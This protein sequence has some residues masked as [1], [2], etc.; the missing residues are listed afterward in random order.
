MRYDVARYGLVCDFCGSFK[1][2]HRPEEG[3]VVGEMDFA[4]AIRVADTN[5]GVTRRLVTCKSC[6]AQML[7]DSDQ[8][9]AMCPFC[10]SAIVL[11]AEE[12]N[13]GIAP[14]A[15]IPFSITKEQVIERFYR[16]N[17]FAFWSPEKFRKGKVLGNITPLYIPYWTFDA[18][19]VTTYSG[20]F[21]YTTGSGDS[22]RTAYYLKTGIMEKHIDD[23]CVCGSRKF[24]NDSML[25]KVATFKPKDL[26]AY[27]PEVLSGMPAE[28]Y[29]ISIDEAWVNAKNGGMN[30]KITEAVKAHEMADSCSELRYS[31]EYYNVKYRYV[32][33]PVW[34][35]G[36]K[37]GGRIYNVVASGYNGTGNCNR[38]LSVAKLIA[39]AAV[40]TAC[41]ILG[42]ILNIGPWMIT[43]GVM[44]FFAFVIIYVAMFFVTLSQQRE[45][46]RQRAIPK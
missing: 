16:W 27:S 40:F 22:A 33:V 13:C 2:L 32:L 28:I 20:K 37:Y 25:N 3:A 38:P 19:T 41:V 30:K 10:G 1:P 42:N 6:G 4:S 18:D 23:Y 44:A 21:G 34:L 24:A 31:T 9:S 26:I 7:Y 17:K 12:A 15:I 45:Q 43:F 35:T 29:T 11:S 14:N 5:W 8:M 39:L 46:E 36:C